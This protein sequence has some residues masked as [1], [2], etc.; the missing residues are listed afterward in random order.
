MFGAECMSRIK[1]IEMIEDIMQRHSLCGMRKADLQEVIN[2]LRDEST[3]DFR[4]KTMSEESDADRKRSR[5][6]EVASAVEALERRVKALE[7]AAERMDEL[8]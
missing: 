3:D 6:N 2:E 1:A 4:D 7:E 5:V 8:P